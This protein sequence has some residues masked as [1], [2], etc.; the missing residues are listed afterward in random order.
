MPQYQA[1]LA[2]HRFTL[3]YTKIQMLLYILCQFFST[4]TKRA[5]RLLEGLKDLYILIKRSR[6]ELPDQP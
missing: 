5:L 4:Q 2:G 3:P 1:A 6:R